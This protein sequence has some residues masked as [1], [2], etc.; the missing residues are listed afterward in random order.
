MTL[1]RAA[2]ILL[3]MI[4]FFCGYYLLQE[5]EGYD[6]QVSPDEE[7]P[8]FSGKNMSNTAYTQD[9]VRN[10]EITST[11]LEYYAKSGD[12]VFESPVLRIYKDGQVLEWEISARRAKLN[13]DHVLVLYDKVIAK[14]LLPTSSFDT[15]ATEKLNIQLDARDFWADQTVRLNGPQFITRGQAMKGNFKDNTAT[16]YE[17]VQGRYETLTP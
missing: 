11:H 1:S 12:T 10:Y 15:M 5:E 4:I 7:L 13:E 8:L 17:H 6:I 2:H 3:V 9:G 14:N 16:L